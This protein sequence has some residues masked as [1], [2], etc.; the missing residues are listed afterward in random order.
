[1][2]GYS[3]GTLERYENSLKHLKGYLNNTHKKDDCNFEDLNYSFIADFEYYLKGDRGIGHNTT[4]KYLRNFKK[5]VLLALKNEWID[6]DPFMRF[7]L[8]LN[9]V[10]KEYLNK[11]EIQQIMGKNFKIERLAQVRDV[12]IFCCYTGL[13]Y[14]DVQRLTINDIQL[15][16]DG[17][18]WI[19]VTRKKTGVQ[20]HIPLLP[21]ASRLIN[22]YK[23]NPESATKRRILPVLSNQKINAYL[24]EIGDLCGIT[25]NITF[26]MARHTF[27]TTVTLSNGV[28]IET[29]SSMLGHKNI[30][31]T[32][33][34]A[35]VVKEKVSR[36]MMELKSKL[37]IVNESSQSI[38]L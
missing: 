3:A 34:Y 9:E 23:N 20:S 30:R 13:S 27:A 11:E 35:K 8:S 37:S 25:K 1:G 24:K 32:Q 33:I 26:H 18:L 16:M 22:K 28:S 4:I 31:T 38:V 7:K 2:N 6:R 10:N 15:G 36:E 14:A 21:E 5:I 12:F 17:E 29:V 19:M